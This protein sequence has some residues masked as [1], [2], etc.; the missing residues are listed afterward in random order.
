MFDWRVLTLCLAVGGL[1]C[2]SG[3]DAEA[4]AEGPPG[5]AAGAEAAAADADGVA[6][7]AKEQA[8]ARE[9]AAQQE[10]D[11]DA[12][13]LEAAPGAIQPT[14]P[15]QT[16][17]A[18]AVD[19]LPPSLAPGALRDELRR[20]SQQLPAQRQNM[21]DER[22]ALAD[23]RIRL[24]EMAAGIESARAALKEETSRLESLLKS[25]PGAAPS[26][27][28]APAMPRDAQ[29]PEADRLELL[30]KSVRG[31]K[32]E[33]AA[34]LLAKLPRPLAA[35]LIL[36]LRPVEAGQIL[37]KLPADVAADL[38]GQVLALPVQEAS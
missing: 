22:T 36:R 19:P 5:V 32:S 13:A 21:Q 34:A 26:P 3:T 12:V 37:E 30:A 15:T 14:S 23:E 7:E 16:K 28:S 18:E 1:A 35:G 20:A 33:Q 8:E 9:A 10:G 38:V 27:A 31:M 4:P 11:A 24:E 6:D 25:R 2:D 17:A 29:A